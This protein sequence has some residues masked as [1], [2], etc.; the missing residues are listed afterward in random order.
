MNGQDRKQ[1]GMLT[2]V[3]LEAGSEKSLAAQFHGHFAL[4]RLFQF[5]FLETFLLEFQ[6]LFVVVCDLWLVGQQMFQFHILFPGA[7]VAWVANIAQLDGADPKVDDEG[8]GFALLLHPLP[9]KLVNADG[10]RTLQGNLKL[11]VRWL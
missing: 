8:E 6:F 9:V 2:N 3:R 7:L 1:K 10:T 4:H 5:H 11:R